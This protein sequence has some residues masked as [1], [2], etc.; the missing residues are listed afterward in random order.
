MILA[1]FVIILMFSFKKSMNSY[2]YN[3]LKKDLSYRMLYVDQNGTDDEKTTI[4]NLKKVE[5]V[6][7]AF[8][9][10]YYLT[11]LYLKQINNENYKN[12]SFYLIG[13]NEKNTP[14]IV[15][16]RNIKEDN[17]IIC[18]IDFYPNSDIDNLRKIKKSSLINTN[19]I[20]DATIKVVHNI[21]DKDFNATATEKNLKVVGTYKNNPSYID[22]NVCYGTHNIIQ[23]IYD[24]SYR[25]IDSSDVYSSINVLVDDISNV[26]SVTSDLTNLNYNVGKVV[27]LNNTIINAVNIGTYIISLFVLLVGIIIIIFIN[28]N[29]MSQKEKNISVLR[30]LGYSKKTIKKILY[31]E[32]IL[33]G[34]TSLIC[35]CVISLSIYFSLKTLVHFRP[36]ILQKFPIDY[37]CSSIVIVT[38]ILII[39]IV[40][41]NI[42]LEKKLLKR[43]VIATSR[44]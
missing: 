38:F 23:K 29:N 41:S 39:T 25:N 22:E 5:H 43:S 37:S 19:K 12:N 15:N 6:E 24:E 16:G 36:F 4:D 26:E 31:I 32:N 27:S 33:V 8:L 14:E 20:I 21:Y 30:C 11:I 35:A 9:N 3:G 7:D 13:I 42:Y 2:I 10:D 28:K 18:P 17:E 34:I 44:D 40:T 1:F